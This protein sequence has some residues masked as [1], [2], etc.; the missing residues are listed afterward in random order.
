MNAAF[1]IGRLCD[2]E[3][4]RKRLLQLAES[5]RM[6]RFN[7]LFL[8]ILNY[9]NLL[10]LSVSFQLYRRGHHSRD[11]IVVELTTTYAISAYHH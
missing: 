5:E 1:A 4:G 10:S 7:V 6:V 3:E 11:C 9:W 8:V 2:M